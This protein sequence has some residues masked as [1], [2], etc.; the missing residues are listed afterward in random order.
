MIRVGL[1]RPLRG[2]S[3]QHLVSARPGPGALRPV[4][5]GDSVGGGF[6]ATHLMLAWGFPLL[7]GPPSAWPPRHRARPE[8]PTVGRGR[9]HTPQPQRPG[10]ACSGVPARGPAPTL[11]GQPGLGEQ[12]QV[13]GW[14]GQ[15]H[16]P[17]AR[18]R[19]LRAPRP[20]GGPTPL[21]QT[22]T[23]QTTPWC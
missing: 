3:P 2:P 7:V 6:R 23:L 4:P 22:L 1:C 17:G 15:E 19:G 12:S 5:T 8:P 10:R 21:V 20:R 16:R 14:G 9:A 18:G 11:S 13:R